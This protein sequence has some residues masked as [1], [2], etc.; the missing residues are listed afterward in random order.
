ME[1]EKHPIIL[2]GLGGRMGKLMLGLIT[3]PWVKK[4]GLHPEVYDVE[5]RNGVS[6]ERKLKDFCCFIDDCKGKGWDISLIG[7]SA[8]G[9]MAIC[10]L[11]ERPDKINKIVTNCSRL[12]VGPESGFR[13]FVN[14][15]KTSAAFAQAVRWCQKIIGEMSPEMKKRIMTLTNRADELVPSETSY[16]EGAV[17]HRLPMMEHIVS[18]GWALWKYQPLV[19]FIKDEQH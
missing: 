13:S 19:A 2:T 7:C 5:W 12:F 14:M 18:I 17:N 4:Y 10:A 8:G 11:A 9:P 16:I 3:R 1:V 6:F 15:T